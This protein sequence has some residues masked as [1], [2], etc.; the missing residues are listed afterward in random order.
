MASFAAPPGRREQRWLTLAQRRVLVAAT[1]TVGVIAAYRVYRSERLKATQQALQT[2]AD[3]LARYS[4]AASSVGRVAAVLTADI[5]SFLASDSDEVPRSL[6]QLAKL[7]RCSEVQDTLAACVSSSVK[8]LMSSSSSGAEGEPGLVD[9]VIEAV[10]SDRGQTLVGLAVRTAAQQSTDTFCTALRQG[11]EAA[12]AASGL[13]HQQQHQQS[14]PPPQQQQ[15][16]ASP[17]SPGQQAGGFYSALSSPVGSPQQQQHHQHRHQHVPYHVQTFTAYGSSIPSPVGSPASSSG[18]HPAV[19]SVLAVLNSPQLLQA[20]DGLVSTAV[21]STVGAYM[22]Q[23]GSSDNMLSSVLHTLSQPGNKALV[24][25]IMS[26][27]SATFCREMAAACVAPAAAVASRPSS[28][29]SDSPGYTLEMQQVEQQ[30]LLLQRS[31]VPMRVPAAAA[32]AGGGSSTTPFKPGPHQH[33]HQQQQAQDHEGAAAVLHHSIS[34]G[35]LSHSSDAAAGAGS[36]SA[37]G[38]EPSSPQSGPSTPEPSVAAADAAGSSQAQQHQ[39]SYGSFAGSAVAGLIL[40]RQSFSGLL[41]GAAGGQGRGHMQAGAAGAGPGLV[42]PA[43]LGP[44]STA[45][46]LFVQAARF[47]EF[48]SLMVDVSRSSTREFVHSLLPSGWARAVGATRQGAAGPGSSSASSSS[49]SASLAVTMALQR[50]Y[51]AV[52]V[53]ILLMVYAVSPKMLM[54]EGGN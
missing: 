3:T 38:S 48:R 47:Q 13:T 25:D 20:V 17:A 43:A 46:S 45:V 7:A 2:A 1:A 54:L 51:T 39:S 4:D 12:L 21:G 11:L 49:S 40:R 30:Q 32:A 36:A 37:S 26:Q 24:I 23:A 33:Q 31:P 9:K 53:L 14:P 27:V 5:Q 15:Q 6:R 18:L 22:A 50:V 41:S 8:G 42:D 29:L 35:A 19:R 44:M 28:R 52:S 34:E 10:L 16:Y